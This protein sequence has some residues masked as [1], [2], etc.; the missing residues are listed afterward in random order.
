[1]I[2]EEILLYHYEPFKKEYEYKKANKISLISHI[3]TND[4]AKIVQF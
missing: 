2:Y 3:L 1:M 4:N